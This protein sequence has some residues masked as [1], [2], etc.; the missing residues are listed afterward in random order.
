MTEGNV[1][2]DLKQ[3]LGAMLFGAK[4]PVTV[5]EMRRVL[6][7]VAKDHG[8]SA[9]ALGKAGES[10][11][12]AALDQIRSDFAKSHPG[13]HLVEVAGGFQ[14]Q[15]DGECA[16][17]L[18][19]FLD[20]RKS[21]R[22]SIPTLE[23]LAIIAYRQPISRSE[24]EAVRGVNVDSIVRH[25]LDMQAIRITGRSSLPGRPMLYGTT[26]LFLEHFGLKGLN[27]LPGVEQLRRPEQE[28]EKKGKKHSDE[29]QTTAD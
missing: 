14:F 2:P 18:R 22:L 6:V 19:E 29:P 25:L 24:I 23:T 15:T 11:I 28:H 26:Q 13:F 9:R 17:W 12:L 27:Y 1:Q 20:V 10:D 3:V 5:A 4:Y 16:L 8:V 7:Q 21:H